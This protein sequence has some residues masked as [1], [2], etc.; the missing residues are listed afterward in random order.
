M[1]GRATHKPN[2]KTTA[3]EAVQ[4]GFML[5]FPNVTSKGMSHSRSSEASKV[6]INTTIID[7]RH[8]GTKQDPFLSFWDKKRSAETSHEAERGALATKIWLVPRSLKCQYPWWR[9]AYVT[10]PEVVVWKRTAG[11]FWR[12]KCACCATMTSQAPRSRLLLPHTLFIQ[13][14]LRIIV[15]ID[16]R[17]WI[18]MK[19]KSMTF[20]RSF[21]QG[22]SAK[23]YQAG[24]MVGPCTLFWSTFEPFVAKPRFPTG[25]RICESTHSPNH[26]PYTGSSTSIATSNMAVNRLR[27]STDVHTRHKPILGTGLPCG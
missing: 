18:R 3:I 9:S 5:A 11:C 22:A 4:S 20:N 10:E 16:E 7:V 24:V 25:A 6:N 26:S 12:H 23:A 19:I 1:L 17:R 14:Q 27:Q 2:S 21:L 8:A 15:L 13:H